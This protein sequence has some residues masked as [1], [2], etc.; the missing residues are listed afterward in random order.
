MGF[1]VG[2]FSWV[3]TQD[4][5]PTCRPGERVA[6]RVPGH[7]GHWLILEA[8]RVSAGRQLK[9]NSGKGTVG[10]SYLMNIFKTLHCSL[11]IIG[12]C[13]YYRIISVLPYTGS[14][15]YNL[16]R[17]FTHIISFVL[18]TPVK[19]CYLH[20]IDEQPAL[21]KLS[22]LP[23]VAQLVN[24]RRNTSSHVFSYPGP[25]PFYFSYLHLSSS[26]ICFWQGRV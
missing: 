9:C 13:V 8:G 24:H 2:A 17:T 7:C 20:F 6:P 11:L 12:I 21:E 19:N 23:K 10:I 15:L 25:F 18:Y 16:E 5:S 22:D 1:V 3:N 26:S 4:L 14:A